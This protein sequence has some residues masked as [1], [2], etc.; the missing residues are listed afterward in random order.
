LSRG[1][2]HPLEQPAEPAPAARPTTEARIAPVPP[3]MPPAAHPR[4]TGVCPSSAPHRAHQRVEA[5]RTDQESEHRSLFL[6][7]RI[8]G[9]KGR[10]HHALTAEKYGAG[11]KGA[12]WSP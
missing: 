12:L 8:G 6:R 7:L 4:A 3:S 11:V 10:L 1:A 5:H 9:R 2:P